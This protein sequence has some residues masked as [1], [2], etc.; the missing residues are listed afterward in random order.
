[1]S[2][3][4]SVLVA[5]AVA[6]SSQSGVPDRRVPAEMSYGDR[7]PW[8]RELN[9]ALEEAGFHPNSGQ[10]FG[11]RTRHAVY[12]FQKHY[13]LP[14]TGKFT[15]FMWDLLDE[16]IRLPEQ[17]EA[18]R[19]EVDLGK[20]VL[21]VVENQQ[22]VL[23]IPISSGNGSHYLSESGGV[24]VASTP[25]G[26][27]RF[28]RHIV[29]MREA[30][31]GLM[32]NPYY[33]WGG[34]AIHGSPSVPNYPASHGCIRVTMWDMDLLLHHFKVG[35]R[36]YVYGKKTPPPTPESTETPSLPQILHFV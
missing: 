28:T 6:V 4:L 5:F 3:L 30:F 12:A 29:G 27:F 32:Y 34:Y 19:V 25:E 14:T 9:D 21:Y 20:Q 11:V 8:A 16:P 33:F 18:D 10:V 13:G 7:G 2:A 31:L 22:V 17:R 36:V 15:P 24:A 1:M 26:T 35:M 23:V